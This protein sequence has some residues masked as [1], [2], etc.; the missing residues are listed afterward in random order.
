MGPGGSPNARQRA[1]WPRACR[2][3]GDLSNVRK[4]SKSSTVRWNYQ[5]KERRAS[6]QRSF[7]RRSVLGYRFEEQRSRLMESRQR[8]FFIVEGD[9]RDAGRLYGNA[10]SLTVKQHIRGIPLIRTWDIQETFASLIMLIE[11]MEK[12]PGI[13]VRSGI[14]LPPRSKRAREASPQTCFARMLR[15]VPGCWDTVTAALVKEFKTLPALQKALSSDRVPRLELANGK[16]LGKT[17][18][19]RLRAYLLDDVTI[20]SSAEIKQ[21]R[22]HTHTHTHTHTHVLTISCACAHLRVCLLRSKVCLSSSAYYGIQYAL[23]R[24]VQ[25]LHLLAGGDFG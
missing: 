24:Q 11:K 21:K 10:L 3:A 8:F 9:L 23:A 15:C 5:F 17:R 14:R 22:A 20:C 1:T 18:W 13:L 16:L 2:T 25:K 19:K 12:P 4:N 7:E 6:C